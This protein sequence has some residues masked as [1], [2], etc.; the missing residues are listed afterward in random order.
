MRWRIELVVLYEPAPLVMT[1][2][3]S[4]PEEQARGHLL[5]ACNDSLFAETGCP[6]ETC[7]CG[8][9]AAGVHSN[10]SLW[11][12]PLSAEAGLAEQQILYNMCSVKDS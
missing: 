1:C 8:W 2:W 9:R 6:Q 12:A 10:T 5:G 7:R 4:E 11:S 3:L